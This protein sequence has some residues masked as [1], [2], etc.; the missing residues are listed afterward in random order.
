MSSYSLNKIAWKKLVANKSSLFALIFIIFCF[1][2][3]FF[4]YLF[5]PDKT[6]YANQ[7]YLELATLPPMTKTQFLVIPKKEY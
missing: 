1:F 4:S 3:S 6:P 2:T 5:I 7:M